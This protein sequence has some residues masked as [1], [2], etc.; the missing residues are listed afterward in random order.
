MYITRTIKQGDLVVTIHSD[1]NRICF[2]SN[3]EV[4]ANYQEA[5]LDAKDNI[6]IYASS[7]LQDDEYLKVSKLL[8]DLDTIVNNVFLEQEFIRNRKNQ[9][10]GVIT[11]F[12][13]TFDKGLTL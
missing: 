7:Y 13:A 12:A 3:G 9:V 4:Y 11:E 2:T 5:Q 10:A 8:N 1:D 6:V